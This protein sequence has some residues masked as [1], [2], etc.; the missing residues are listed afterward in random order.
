[1]KYVSAL[2]KFEAFFDFFVDQPSAKEREN[3]LLTFEQWLDRFSI[4]DFA[5]LCW[6]QLHVL[7]WCDLQMCSCGG[8]SP[9]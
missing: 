5:W 6:Q 3:P 4:V 2:Q 8:S 7:G 9:V 1:M